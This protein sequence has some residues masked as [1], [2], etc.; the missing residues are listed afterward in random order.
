MSWDALWPLLALVAWI[1]ALFTPLLLELD[2]AWP[3]PPGGQS[4]AV[5]WRLGPVRLKLPS[6][7]SGAAGGGPGASWHQARAAALV[8]RDLDR[9]V[10]EVRDLKGHLELGTGEPASSALLSG[11]GWA[12]WGAV[13]ELLRTRVRVRPAPQLTV[14]PR[15]DQG[16]VAVRLHCI[17]STRL[18]HV[19]GAVPNLKVLGGRRHGRKHAPHGQRHASHHG[20]LERDG[21][22]Q[23]HLG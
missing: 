5:W 17:L 23:H 20:K 2:V 1:G 19:I 8:V 7:L 12:F 22:R 6:R 13:L 21:G 14:A 4:V 11:V 10:E 3:A 16:G 18:V 15:F 9:L